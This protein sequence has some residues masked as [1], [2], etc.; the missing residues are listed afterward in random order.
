[1]KEKEKCSRREFE[2]RH[3]RKAFTQVFCGG[4]DIGNRL[5]N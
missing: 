4:G 2:S 5:G 3:L 1:M